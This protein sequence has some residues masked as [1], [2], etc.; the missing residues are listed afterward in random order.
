VRLKFA[1]RRASIFS[2][3]NDVALLRAEQL[4]A[5][6]QIHK[7]KASRTLPA[8]LRKEPQDDDAFEKHCYDH[9]GLHDRTV[10][11]PGAK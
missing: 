8:T 5:T 3:K 4:R 2:L 11:A 9:C 6:K 1:A 7:P 10:R